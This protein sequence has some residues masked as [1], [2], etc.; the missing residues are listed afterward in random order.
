MW[1]AV[2]KWENPPPIDYIYKTRNR[3]NGIQPR[4]ID[5]GNTDIAAYEHWSGSMQA[6]TDGGERR[7]GWLRA[8]DSGGAAGGAGGESRG[9]A[10][11]AV[12]G[13]PKK[14]GKG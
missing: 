4:L 9:G 11:G 7:G 13:G 8:G 3:N 1:P 2:L 14:E 10:Q 6:R 12:Q 5:D